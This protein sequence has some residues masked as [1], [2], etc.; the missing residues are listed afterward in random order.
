MVKSCEYI[1]F[2]IYREKEYTIIEEKNQHLIYY[3]YK[4]II[5]MYLNYTCTNYQNNLKMISLLF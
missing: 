2:L 1:L 4:N 5:N 3:K